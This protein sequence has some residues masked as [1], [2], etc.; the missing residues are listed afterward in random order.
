MRKSQELHACLPHGI[1]PRHASRGFDAG[2]RIGQIEAQIDLLVDA[3]GSNRL[4]RDPEVAQVADDATVA[5]IQIDVSEALNLVAIVTTAP[6]WCEADGLCIS[7]R[8]HAKIHGEILAKAVEAS[9]YR[10]WFNLRPS[11]GGTLFLRIDLALVGPV[12]CD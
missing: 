4:N 1:S 10:R 12:P 5:L 3:Q 11:G 7:G 8:R 9:Q 6:D 2:S